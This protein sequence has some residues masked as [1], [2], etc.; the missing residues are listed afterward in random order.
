[1][2][3]SIRPPFPSAPSDPA[4]RRLGVGQP[5]AHT[6]P[7]RA[8]LIVVVVLGLMLVAIPLYLWRRPSI[9]SKITLDAGGAPSASSSAATMASVALPALPDAGAIEPERVKLSPVRKVRCG[10]SAKQVAE[11]EGCDSLAYFE[12]ALVDAVK[13][14]ADCAPQ[15]AK[16]GSINFV[17]QIDFAR[18]NMNV[19]PG[20]SGDWRGPRARRATKC[21][22]NAL[23]SPDWASIVHQHRYYA[24]AVM[25]TFPGK[26][27]SER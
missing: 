10:A 23:P 16:P 24:I 9:A 15:S 7:I 20:A 14:S 4:L 13:A 6:R 2:S 11:T 25:A 12:K 17:L 21:V 26:S 8:Q 1:M 27:A 18:K 19:F 5:G 22:T 3:N